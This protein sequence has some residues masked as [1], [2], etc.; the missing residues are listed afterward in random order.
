MAKATELAK[1]YMT[2]QVPLN[3]AFIVSANFDPNS[4][5]AIYEVTAYKN[6][7]DIYNSPEGLVFKTDGNRAHILV[8]PPTYPERFTEPVN[9][10]SGFS[11]PFRFSEC[12]ILTGKRQ[13]RIM[14]P[15]THTPL[16]SSFTILK[17]EKDNF[18]YLFYPSEDV[19]I[20]IKK[21]V[22][23]SLFNDCGINKAI[24]V[25]ASGHFLD[26]LKGFNI[27]KS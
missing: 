12:T 23:D 24:S 20:A 13:E 5:Y 10:N 22:A 11:I 3:G 19:Y 15:Q 26:T 1:A 4:I 27:W 6:V 16:Y 7:K 18:S 17:S 25:E 8:E 2:E 14:L 9:R 21:F